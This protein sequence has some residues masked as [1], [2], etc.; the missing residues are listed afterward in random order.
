MR[1]SVFR[2]DAEPDVGLSVGVVDLALV[3]IRRIV[4]RNAV[5]VALIKDAFLDRLVGASVAPDPKAIRELL[6]ELR[7]AVIMPDC[8]AEAYI[9]AAARK[10]GQ[11]WQDD[12]LSFSVVTLGTSRL[13]TMLRQVEQS[14]VEDDIDS[15]ARPAVLVIVPPGE[16][17]TLGASV[18]A[19]RLRR[20][21]LAVSTQLSLSLST[22]D[23]STLFERRRF[24]GAMISVGNLHRLEASNMLIRTLRSMVK[25]T[26]PIL[27]GGALLEVGHDVLFA[28]EADLVTSD[29]DKA[30][31]FLGL[32][33]AR[34]DAGTA[35][36]VA[37]GGRHQAR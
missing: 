22:S 37:V 6:S 21:G 36:P 25:G 11:G 29:L 10:L 13:A 19:S 17:H 16:Q 9:P 1:D 4:A 8:I 7:R 35:M 23:L 12:M 5:G 18:L 2:A 15:L 33:A 31:T 34:S 30:L 3:A 32:D 20:M 28:R 14:S 24:S 26:M 27:V